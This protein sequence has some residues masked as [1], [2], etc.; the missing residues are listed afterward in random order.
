VGFRR[1]ISDAD[2][3]RVKHLLPGPPGQRGGAAEGDRRLLDAVSWIARTGAARRD[4]PER[5]G[6]WNSRRRRSDRRAAAGRF[7]ALAAVFRDP[8]PDVLVPDSTAAPARPCPAGSKKSGTGPGA[9]AT[10]PR[11]AAGAGPGPSC[12]AGSTA[13][14]GR[15]S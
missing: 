8:D 5:L 14:A 4:P 15:S 1:A 6:D 11:A 12:T 10:G 9:G 3:D 13:P 7:A 2:W